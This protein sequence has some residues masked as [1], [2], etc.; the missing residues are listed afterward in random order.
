[1]LSGLARTLVQH[2]LIEPDA[3]MAIQKKADAAQGRFIDELVSSGRLRATAVARFASDTFGLPLMDLAAFDEDMLPENL[4]DT[5]LLAESRILPIARRGSRLTVLLSDPTDLQAID[6]VKFW[7]QA[8]IDPIVV[9]HHTLSKLIE[10]LAPPSDDETDGLG[11]DDLGG[12]PLDEAGDG[13]ATPGAARSGR[14]NG[15]RRGT[16]GDSPGADGGVAD[17]AALF[18]IARAL[19]LNQLIEPEQAAAIQRKVEAEQ[20][21][22]IDELVSSGRLRAST[23]AHFVSDTFGLPMIDLAAVD[24]TMLLKDEI[25]TKLLAES[26]ILPIAK[27]GNRLTVLLSDPTDLQSVDRIKFRAQATVDPIVVEHDKLLKLVEQLAKALTEQLERPPEEE[28]FSDPEM[29]AA[30][31][32]DVRVFDED[33]P[34]RPANYT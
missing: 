28:H 1:V 31:E 5:R 33:A 22:F 24:A 2:G 16:P 7:A 11:D 29:Y 12:F 20:G 19:V 27:R 4:I 17:E 13:L 3:A 6:R 34:L 21:R 25:D 26:R 30:V 32:D 14:L 18:G 9:E 23:L 10:R 15:A 8:T